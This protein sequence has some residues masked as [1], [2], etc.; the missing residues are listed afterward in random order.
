[1]SRIRKSVLDNGIKVITEKMAD[2]ESASL[3]VWVKTGSRHETQRLNGISHLIEHM[4]FK[5]TRRRSA[6]DVARE[7]ESV[8]GVLN[9]F[10]GREFTCFYSK[11][12]ADNIP[13][14]TDLLS[15]IFMNSLFDKVELQKEKK[16]HH[17]GDQDGG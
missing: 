11:V 5:G 7:I 4:L 2:V 13:L 17:A 6:L 1:M 9:A 14:A 16:G 8:G 3:G 15:D 12:L 10:T